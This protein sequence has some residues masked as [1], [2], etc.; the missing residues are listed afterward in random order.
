[1]M[2]DEIDTE[3]ISI[4]KTEYGMS[5]FEIYLAYREKNKDHPAHTTIGARV[6]LLASAKL[7][8]VSVYP[9]PYKTKGRGIKEVFFKLPEGTKK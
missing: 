9:K 2:L 6:K 4:L 8:G 1:M 3:I 7:I 5:K